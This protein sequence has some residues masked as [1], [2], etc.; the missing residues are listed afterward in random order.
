MAITGVEA[1]YFLDSFR[2]S[3]NPC[4]G[5]MTM[6]SRPFFS[7]GE[8]GGVLVSMLIGLLVFDSAGVTAFVSRSV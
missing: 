3:E 2:G 1:L 6:S 4:G 7:S 5:E 8:R